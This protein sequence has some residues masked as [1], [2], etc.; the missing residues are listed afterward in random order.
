MLPF[1]LLL[2]YNEYRVDSLPRFPLDLVPLPKLA[3]EAFL[4]VL[5]AVTCLEITLPSLHAL[6]LTFKE[7]TL[8]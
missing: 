8:R 3:Y 4:A 2:Q 7:P 1:N 5:C 6:P